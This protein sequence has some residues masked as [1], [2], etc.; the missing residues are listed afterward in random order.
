MD[1][2][3]IGILTYN[4]E[5]FIAKCLKS[6]LALEYE[7]L[8]I[9]ISDDYSK[10]NTFKIIQDI[11]E[12]S[13][14]SHHIIL[15]RNEVNL[16][17]AGNFNKTFYELATGDFLITLG[18]DDAIKEDYLV[19][20]LA[21]F[22][23]DEEVMMVDFNADLIDENDILKGSAATLNFDQKKTD[24]KD[25]LAL[26][27]IP[28]FAPGRTIRKA[29]ISSFNPISKECPTED[30]VL[31]VR[32]LLLGK[33]CR[34]DKK[35]IL[36]RRHSGNISSVDNLRKISNVRIVAQYVR[37]AITL[38]DTNY[39]DDETILKILKRFNYEYKRREIVYSKQNMYIKKIKLIINR[40]FYLFKNSR[41]EKN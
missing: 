17:L 29:L 7:N 21:C 30:S 5:K 32:A 8:E 31:V 2:I 1:K 10:D 3:T 20:A 18:G 11:V 26:R 14:T 25:Y 4:H 16:G 35:V 39:F 33:H 28:S 15:N 34:V 41:N 13:Q 27:A 9:I 38:Y 40:I 36:Y 12:K 24:L 23:K 6:V 19:D 22:S 37:D